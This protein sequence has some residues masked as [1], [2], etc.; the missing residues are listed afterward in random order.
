MLRLLFNKPTIDSWLPPCGGDDVDGVDPEK[1]V[2][3]K[4]EKKETEYPQT[5]VLAGGNSNN[6]NGEKEGEEE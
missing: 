4:C 2:C 5:Q 1:F 6:D 3:T